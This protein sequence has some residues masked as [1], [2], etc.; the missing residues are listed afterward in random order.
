MIKTAL[1]V[2]AILLTFAGYIPYVRDVMR[3]RTHPHAYSWFMWATTS[4][5]IFGLQLK[6][7]AGTGAFVTL[8]AVIVTYLIFGLALKYGKSDITKIDT[9]FLVLAI[10]AASLWLLAKQPT[11]SVILLTVAET[12]AFIPTIR[13]SWNKPYGETLSSYGLNALRF[14]LALLALKHY[15]LLTTLYPAAWALSNGSFWVLLL[16]RRQ[17]IPAPQVHHSPA[18]TEPSISL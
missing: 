15:N 3:K 11:L 5:I 18:H 1:G 8:A 14:S 10:I 7:G 17:A 6:G 13:K 9:L 4:L 16:A 2:A 12:L